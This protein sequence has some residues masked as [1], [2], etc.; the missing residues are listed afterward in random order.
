MDDW[1]IAVGLTAL[2]AA[3]VYA[4]VGRRISQRPVPVEA[5]FAALQFN[6]WWYGLAADTGLGGVGVLL[7]AQG[8][9]SF[10]LGLTLDIID[11]LAAVA[12]L[13]GLV[14]YLTYVYTGRH[15]LVPLSL[16]YFAFY[17]SVLYFEF[18]QYPYAI[19]VQNGALVLSYHSPGGPIWLE[20]FVIFGLI[21]PEFAGAFLY[22]SLYFRAPD[23]TRR[24]RIL[25]VGLSILLWFGGALL[26][27]ATFDGLLRN[28][29]EVL[30]ALLSLI[31][32]APPRSV[33][34]RLRLATLAAGAGAGL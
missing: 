19:S 7:A 14:G 15:Y 8:W 2:V 20:A 34:E 10:P 9:L 4:F 31:A 1:L 22:L 17:A 23:P 21:V 16:F 6:I 27:P 26:T 28:L 3:G 32:Y 5:Q 33:R 29:V 11:V 30:A 13:W 24:F 25:L 18:A 12:A